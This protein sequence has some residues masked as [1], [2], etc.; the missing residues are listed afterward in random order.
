MFFIFKFFSPEP[1]SGKKKK[2]INDVVC[3]TSDNIFQPNQTF[4]IHSLARMP[5]ISVFHPNT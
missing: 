5:L 1:K 4:Q 3:E 2:I